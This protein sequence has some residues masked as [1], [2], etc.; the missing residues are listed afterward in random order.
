M[1]I[2][3]ML[4]SGKPTLSFEVFPPK[5]DSAYESVEQ[6]VTEI[7]ALHPHFMSVTYGAGGGTS[8]YTAAIAAGIQ[9]KYSV[10]AL[11][12]ITCVS[13]TKEAVEAQ[14]LR[15][16]DAG[17]ENVKV[18]A[19]GI[20]RWQRE[21]YPLTQAV[22]PNPAP[23]SFVPQWRENWLVSHDEVVALTASQEKILVDVRAPER[24]RGEV[25]PL[26]PVAGH[27]P[28]AIN[29]YYEL[30]YTA[31]GLKPEAE[32]KEIFKPLLNSVI[33]SGAIVEACPKGKNHR[34]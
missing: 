3:E 25:E 34:E 28:T 11:A 2:S 9:Q 30:P 26:D 33:V 10:P 32:L 13:S 16:K 7:A 4:K 12:H 23:S 29:I 18:L 6:A 22:T 17:I 1:K 21:G 5:T 14:L 8:S 24:Y 15:L 20:G 19:G 31:D 27:I